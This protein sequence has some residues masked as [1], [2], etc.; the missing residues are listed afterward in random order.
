[1]S[2]IATKLT[3]VAENQQK[4]YDAGKQAEYDAFWDAYQTIGERVNYQASFG[5]GGWTNATF[6]PKYDINPTNASAMFM[7]SA[8]ANLEVALNNAGVTLDLRNAASTSQMFAG[9][10]VIVLPELDL[11]GCTYGSGTLYQMFM[12][13]KN[14]ATIRKIILK[15]AGTDRFTA[16]DFSGCVAL[17]NVVFE[18]VIG[19][20]GLSLASSTKLTHDSLVS[21]I[22][23]LADYSGDTSGTTWKITIG[24]ANIAKLTEDELSIAYNKGWTVA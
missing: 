19:R 13:C 18:G 12:A 10:A 3:T 20:N 2:D 6:K 21:I 16:N 9:S 8:I 4:V 7:Y 24:S 1:M 23:C 17:E 22:N 5:G 15:N 14:L 11:R